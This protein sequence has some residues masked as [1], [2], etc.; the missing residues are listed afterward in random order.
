VQPITRKGDR[1]HLKVTFRNCD[2]GSLLA[3]GAS[4]LDF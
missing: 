3:D 1:R 4:Q 2:H